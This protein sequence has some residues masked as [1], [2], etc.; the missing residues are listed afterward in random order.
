MEGLAGFLPFILL[1]AVFWLLIV[2]PQRRRQ[3]ELRK[4]QDTLGPGS[5]VMLGSGIFGTVTSVED[6]T[7]HV[8]ISPGTT[9]KVARQAVVRVLTSTNEPETDRPDESG[10]TD[11][12]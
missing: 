7:A 5:E 1:A 4:T 8:E 9:I 12:Q 3:K 10:A 6:D 2:Q 11:E